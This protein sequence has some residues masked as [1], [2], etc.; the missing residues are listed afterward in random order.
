MDAYVLYL[1]STTSFPSW[2]SPVRIR[3]PAPSFQQLASTQQQVG[4]NWLRLVDG[5]GCLQLVHRV[6]AAL[7]RSS[8][9]DVLV[10]INGVP[11][12]LGPDLRIDVELLKQTA[13]G[14]SHH[15]KIPPPE[16]HGLQLRAKMPA[17]AVVFPDRRSELFR[18]KHPSIGRGVD[19]HSLPLVNGGQKPVR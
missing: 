14:P 8:G 15:Q 19:G 18:R 10:Y 9:I 5:E 6:A 2:T 11:H 16:P 13:V 3:S 7:E 17:L 1:Q 4:S 12:L